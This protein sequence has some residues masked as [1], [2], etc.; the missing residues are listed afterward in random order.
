M[1]SF[2]VLHLPSS[3]L[4]HSSLWEEPLEMSYNNV[5]CIIDVVKMMQHAQLSQQY[6]TANDLH[7]RIDMC[8]GR[9]SFHPEDSS[10]SNLNVLSTDP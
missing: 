3:G 2:N 8:F 10:K 9:S 1:F 5:D 6:I 4:G 7:V